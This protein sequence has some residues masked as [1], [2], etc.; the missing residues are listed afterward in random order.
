M[1]DYHIPLKFGSISQ[2][3]AFKDTPHEIGT[4]SRVFL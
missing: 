4:D 1:L 3:L 2:N